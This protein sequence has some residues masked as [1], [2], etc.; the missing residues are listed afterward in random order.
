[1]ARINLLPWREELRKQRQREFISIAAGSIVL[2]LL[3]VF[4]VHLHINGLID[5]QDSR[6]QFLEKNIKQV[7]AKIKE[8]KELEKQK[9][10]LIARMKVIE[11]LQGNRPLVVHLFDEIVK[12]V[13]D[14]LY[15]AN[16]EQKQSELIIKGR[17]Q[18][19]ARVSAFMRNLDA[20]AW[21]RQPVLDVIEVSKDKKDRTRS[22][23]LHVKAVSEKPDNEKAASK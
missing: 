10:Q 9:Q 22:F 15:L 18:S 6:N 7:E 12:A 17:A 13:P 11:Q 3:V 19:N 2:M 16:L 14:G 21:F 5:N 4:Y 8:I 20:S 1:M 23:S